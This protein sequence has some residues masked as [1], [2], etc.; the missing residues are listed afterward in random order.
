MILYSFCP[1]SQKLSIFIPRPAAACADC[2][3]S[4]STISSALV[5]PHSDSFPCPCL[6]HAPLSRLFF[7]SSGRSRPDPYEPQDKRPASQWALHSV[8]P[9]T[10]LQLRAP[11]GLR[12]TGATALPWEALCFVSIPPPV[13]GVLEPHPP[14]PSLTRFLSHFS[15]ALYS[16]R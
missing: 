15:A 13:C 4:P 3:L 2:F 8:T 16:D 5:S 10:L 1:S 14:I 6:G 12:N 7:R 11:A 9:P